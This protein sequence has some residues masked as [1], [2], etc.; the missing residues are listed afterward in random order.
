MFMHSEGLFQPRLWASQKTLDARAGWWRGPFVTARSGARWY[1]FTPR[2]EDVRLA[3][4]GVTALIIRWGGHRG[5]GTVAEHQVRVAELLRQRGCDA[6]TQLLG[7]LHDAAE[8]YPPGDVLAPVLRGPWLLTWPTRWMK[9]RAER[10]VRRRLQL[11]LEMPLAV[12]RADVEV[13]QREREGRFS[14]AG[15][16]PE[17]AEWR[18]WVLVEKLART[19][20]DEMQEERVEAA[21]AGRQ[22]RAVW[23]R[24][25]AL[26]ELA[27]VASQEAAKMSKA[28]MWAQKGRAA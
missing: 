7:A 24:V 9:R 11:P 17:H 2:P 26:H 21:K 16:E 27:S 23:D 28:L 22:A 3:D 1:P 4:L 6:W 14:G 18:W 15:W 25:V 19:A 10:A 20:A 12:H 5:R 8:V 13:Q